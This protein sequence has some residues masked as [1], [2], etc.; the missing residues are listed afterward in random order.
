MSS[1][2]RISFGWLLI[3]LLA[4]LLLTAGGRI[5]PHDEETVFRMTANL[6]ERGQLT[7][8]Q[9]TF[10]VEPQTYPLFLPHLQPRTQDTTWTGLASNGQRYPLYTHAQPLLQTPLYLI[11][12]FMAGGADS[13][14]AV[15]VVR[16]GVS[17]LNPIVLAL[18]G[19]VMALFGRR[20]G[21]SDRLCVALG[22]TY[23]LG[24][25]AL[26]Y[27]HTNFSDPT[28]GL[29]I[30]LAVYGGFRARSEPATRWYA[31][32]GVACGTAMY[33]RERALILLPILLGY[34]VIGRPRPTLRMVA[35]LL[36][37]VA[38]GGGL[39]GA[40]NWLR[41]GT[42]FTVGY[43]DWV[44]GTGFETPLILGLFG[45]LIS[46]GKGVLWYSPIVW[47]GLPGLVAMWRV[48]RAEAVTITLLSIISLIFYALYSFWT[49]GWNW[50]PR[51]LLPLLPLWLLAM[52]QWLQTTT[53]TRRRAMWGLLLGLTMLLNLPAALVD[54]SRYMVAFS[55]RDPQHYL[56]RAI[57][58]V[59]D[60]P[61]T[62]QWPT[63]IELVGG[64]TRSETWLAAQS[65]IDQHLQ[66]YRGGTSV[67]ELSTHLMWVDE[68]F[69]LNVP[70]LWFLHLILL[71]FSPLVIGLVVIGLVIIL[72]VSSRRI[73]QPVS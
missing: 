21:F 34:A 64:Y 16:F 60:S 7:V 67:E 30:T 20:L 18:T 27:A 61:L 23:S 48:R 6:L 58:S 54:Q 43:A 45:L 36:L 25:I 71:G 19:W 32:I 49:G 8:T 53:S 56:D 1:S 26:V 3:F 12:R 37:P 14:R 62:Q 55:E 11:A 72:M 40:W 73:W 10:T 22:V 47:L 2:T 63:A 46:P 15:I 70:D 39:L 13:L 38:I 66:S 17:L 9:Q 29:L 5:A 51:Y 65:A 35:A 69:R 42:P 59:E 44:P 28:L 4:A 50:G 52:G 57:L 24:T 31:L 41:F 68:F 33:L